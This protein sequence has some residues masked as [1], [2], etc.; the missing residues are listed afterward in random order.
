M[1]RI[2][3]GSLGG[4]FIPSPPGLGARPTSQKARE[5]LFSILAADVP[6]ALFLDLFA[7]T[8]AIGVEAL[9]RGAG[10][11]VFVESDARRCG[12]LK[13]ALRGLSLENVSHVVRADVMGRA[14]PRIA[15]KAAAAAGSGYGI[16]FADPPYQLPGVARIP[17]IVSG[18][19]A[20]EGA[21]ILVV[22][23]GANAVMPD[24]AGRFSKYRV[25]E[26]GSAS[27]TFYKNDSL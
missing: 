14:F 19:E 9:S 26:Y 23:H 16:V 18:M 6:G 13:E 7:G 4:R 15:A 20:A 1:L 5:S 11:A 17:H 22:E 21:A 3:A 24:A 2:V 27:M 8:G 12:A 10:R 25:K